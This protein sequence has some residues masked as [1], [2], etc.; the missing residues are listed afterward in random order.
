MSTSSSITVRIGGYIASVP[1]LAALRNY[2][3]TKLQENDTIL[4]AGAVVAGDNNGGAFIWQPSAQDADNNSTLISPNNGSTSGRWRLSI[5]RGNTGQKGDKG[6]TGDVT[7]AATQAKVDAQ[8]AATASAASATLS[9]NK[10]AD[11][12]QSAANAAASASNS[13]TSATA[14]QNSAT[15]SANSATAS[16]TSA[17]ASQSS[18]AAANQSALNSAASAT[19]SQQYADNSAT[20]RTGAET[21]RAG[22]DSAFATTITARDV[23]T[24]LR[25]VTLVA[26]DDTFAARD[27]TYIA[28]DLAQQGAGTAGNKATA[29]D[30][31]ASQASG[32]A[33]S[34]LNSAQTA[35]ASRQANAGM[36]EAI[37]AAA[38]NKPFAIAVGTAD[39]VFD[40]LGVAKLASIPASITVINT[41]GYYAPGDGGGATYKRVNVANTDPYFA[42]RSA[43][44]LK[45]DGTTDTTNGGYWQFVLIN[46]MFAVEQIGAQANYVSKNNKGRDN[47]AILLAAMNYRPVAAYGAP[48]IRLNHGIYYSSQTL[49][50]HNQ[51]FLNGDSERGSGGATGFAR[52]WLI[53]PNNTK[54]MQINGGGQTGTTTSNVA[55]LG[56]CSE[57]RIKGIV[58]M[59]ETDASSQIGTDLTAHALDFRTAC[60]VENCTFTSI[61]GDGIHIEAYTN[62][63]GRYGEASNWQTI[64]CFAHLVGGHG[65]FAAGADTNIGYCEGFTTQVCG[66]CGIYDT[67]YYVNVYNSIHLA[68][69]GTG[70]VFNNG[71]NYSLIGTAAQGAANPPGADTQASETTWYYRATVAAATTNFPQWI[72]GTTY[73]RG[74][75]VYAS[76]QAT[77]SG[78]YIEGGG[79]YGWAHAP[80]ATV[81]GPDMGWTSYS[82]VFGDGQTGQKIGY[83]RSTGGDINDPAYPYIKDAEFTFIGAENSALPSSQARRRTIL[84]HRSG[85]TN[86][87]LSYSAIGR[88]EDIQFISNAKPVWSF[89]TAMTTR[90][91]GTQAPQPNVFVAHDM[92]LQDMFDANNTRRIG[93]RNAIPTRAGTYA[94]GERYFNANAGP[95]LVDYWVCTTAGNIGSVAWTANDYPGLGGI[96][97][98]DNQQWIV[99]TTGLG[100]TTVAPTGTGNF[101]DPTTSMVWKPIGNTPPVFTGVTVPAVATVVYDPPSIAAGSSVTTTVN[102]TGSYQGTRTADVTTSVDPGNLIITAFCL[103]GQIRVRY[104]NPTSAAIDM[105]SHNLTVVARGTI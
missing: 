61:A 42:F 38:A 94:R 95:G 19:S 55:G 80:N 59:Q 60:I 30:A 93:M 78:V 105:A 43:D 2:P 23:T 16:Q 75:P 96:R 89:G 62:G 69:Y 47:Y 21:A 5:G 36:A 34:A 67:S 101:T 44:R 88:G 20:S 48:M 82:S 76:N 7:P 92:A 52:T 26:R 6:D 4:V 24:N 86:V 64:G 25:D 79:A 50:P 85:P 3:T 56:S 14:S 99:I 17:G 32:S 40:T 73:K 58:F 41:R 35:E 1:N 28:R 83:L 98:S 72:S 8:S 13:A 22:A 18:A 65:H 9:G 77:M 66:L 51:F 57:S 29:A 68:G 91:F 49:E 10:A 27:L 15:T 46:N 87:E 84:L 104:F 70:G 63:G 37:Q 103:D 53:F 97:V 45:L 54:C 90:T 31:S 12:L 11:S 71:K 33:L 102:V 39:T 100:Y 81:L 74:G